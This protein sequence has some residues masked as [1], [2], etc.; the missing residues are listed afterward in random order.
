[1]LPSAPPHPTGSISRLELLAP[2][3]DLTALKAALLAG[4]DAIYLGGKRFGA[5][6]FAANFDEAALRQARRIT[7]ALGK[8]LYITFNTLVFDHEWP[9]MLEALD[10]YES[11]APDALIL[12]DLGVA[13]TLARRGS[14]I[15]RHLSTQGTWNG[16]GGIELLRDLGFT[17]VILPREMTLDEIQDLR[18]RVPFEIEVFVH[19]AMCF[20]VSGRCFWSAALGTRSGNRGT[21]A[22]PCRKAYRTRKGESGFFFSPRDLRLIEHLPPLIKAGVTTFKIEGRMKDADYVYRV[23][24]AYRQAL[25]Q[26]SPPD[27]IENELNEVFS[28]P[29]HSGFLD[30]IPGDWVT[31]DDPGRVSVPIGETAAPRRPDGLTLIRCHRLLHPGDGLSW[32]EGEERAGARVTFVGNEGAP[33][34][35]LLI[36][37]LPPLPAGI[38]LR[39]SDQA[40]PQPWMTEWNRDWE[41]IPIDLFWSGH[42]DQPLAVETTFNGQA[43]RLRTE[44]RLEKA[45]ANGLESGI[46][47]SRF[48]QIGEHFRVARHV[49]KALDPGL[50]IA[51]SALKNLKR[52]LLDTL[53][54]LETTP[55]PLQPRIPVEL[56]LAPGPRITVRPTNS[57]PTPEQLSLQ[58][59]HRFVAQLA[60]EPGPRARKPWPQRLI[61]RFWQTGPFP[62][63]HLAADRWLIPFTGGSIPA[64]YPADKTG[65]W[66]PP[67]F[68]NSEFERIRRLL[69]TLPPQ[70]FLCL[71]WEAFRLAAELPQHR[72][73][74]DWSF[75]LV[76][77]SAVRLVCDRNVEVTA[78]REWPFRHPPADRRLV[79]PLALNPLVSFSRFPSATS[80][81]DEPLVNSHGDRFFRLPLGNGLHGIFLQ[82]QPSG[83]PP[84]E[85]L[86]VQLDVAFGP[87]ER[88][89]RLLSELEMRFNTRR[90]QSSTKPHNDE[91]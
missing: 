79:W 85:G 78:G 3:G 18:G 49:F 13:A 74:V 70:E 63:M 51:P 15:P 16:I 60:D 88:P 44:E 4:A 59:S 72:F 73:R 77:S 36:R 68:T 89:E 45:R 71:S 6:A 81:T 30:G 24:K 90:W 66:L 91:R 26:A 17:R 87:G 23:V 32:Q 19:G 38:E 35:H 57:S 84:P 83:F 7:R 20:S 48:G 37:G 76:N 2:A 58:H 31:P 69:D 54:R 42:Q 28:R 75:N 40:T 21:C 64:D 39:R 62:R 11:L 67:I 55:Q 9:L 29:S 25:D 86:D 52:Q 22:Q 27:R 80:T 65:F 14:R 8:K 50:F 41:K 33:P 34:G 12:Q 56:T 46:L 5:R 82:G 1:M 47:E 10:L 43:L 61:V 53:I